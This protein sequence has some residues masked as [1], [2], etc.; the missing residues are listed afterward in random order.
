MTKP[1]HI[2]GTAFFILLGGALVAANTEPDGSERTIIRNAELGGC[3]DTAIEG[4]WLFAVGRDALYVCDISIPAAPRRVGR[5]GGLGNTRQITVKNSIAYI[6]SRER[7]LFVVDVSAPAAPSLLS[8]YDTIEL[9]TGIAVSGPIAYVACRNY[10]VELVDVS[11]PARPRHLSTVRTGEAQ[12][13]AVR[14][15][16]LYVGVWASRELVVCDVRNPWQPRILSRTPL[17]GYGD[18]VDVRGRYCFVATGHHARGM[19]RRDETDPAF[20]H[21]HGLEVFDVSD[22]S[23]PRFVSRVKFPRLHRLG[24]DMWSVTVSGRYAYVAD[25]YNGLFVVDVADIANPLCIARRRLP[26]VKPRKD[27]SPAAG[28]AVGQG[29]VYVAGAW[30]DLHVVEEPTAR[31]PAPVAES[32]AS[33]P[34]PPPS[35]DP[36]FQQY[37]PE[38]Q[39]W[40]V[41]A[42][43][44]RVFAA[45]GRDGLHVLTLDK[46]FRLVQRIATRDVAVDVAATEE[47]VYV[48]EGS[49]GLSIWERGPDGSLAPLGRFRAGT[50]PVRQVVAPDG[51]RYV[52]LAVGQS[53]LYIVDVTDPEHPRGVLRDARPGLLYGEQITEGLFD[54]RYACCFWHVS[55]F[56][57]YD[58]EA[59]PTPEFSGDNWACRVGAA[60]GMALLPDGRRALVTTRENAYVIVTRGERRPLDELPRYGVAGSPMLGKP[61]V[62][63][64]TLYVTHRPAGDVTV[65]D[66]S[67]LQRPRSLERFDLSGNPGVII[68]HRGRVLIPAGYQGLLARP[69][70]ANGE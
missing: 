10:G 59:E 68:E 40:A 69:V 70:P 2:G 18:G 23:A 60:N 6:T 3:M 37:K 52:L 57:W 24:M 9:A 55:G 26:Y 41:S 19:R 58:L 16:L 42:V 51:G 28:L 17:D 22:P 8:H 25:T 1:F 13:C 36:R 34:A 29:V 5:L 66:I 63:G 44:E 54:K 61:S 48:A 56:H 27:F 21:G 11:Q 12:S 49:A 64:N 20:G 39:V 65:L 7:G 35:E 30:S 46:D 4:K 14:N 43:G 53:W 31:P 67:D 32:A 33:V 50:L 45:C 47:R 62:F 38:G 15:G